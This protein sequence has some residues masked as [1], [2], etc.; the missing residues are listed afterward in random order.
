MILELT[1]KERKELWKLA[2]DYT[3]NHTDIIHDYNNHSLMEL[4]IYAVSRKIYDKIFD[5][6]A[7]FSVSEVNNILCLIANYSEDNTQTQ[8]L[9]NK[10]EESLHENND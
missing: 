4:D 9:Y 3:S 5:E 2:V 10:V 8:N 1:D 7:S 6:T